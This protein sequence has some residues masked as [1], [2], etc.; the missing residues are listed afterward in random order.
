MYPLVISAVVPRP[1][2]FI[3]SQSLAGVRNLSPYS[4]FNVMSHDPPY[5]CIG[6]WGPRALPR[7]IVALWNTEVAKLLRTAEMKERMTG[8]GIDPAGG[9]PAEFRDALKSDIER[10]QKVIKAA[11]IKAAE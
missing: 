7:E 4:Y 1:I 6:M 5:V 10:W 11:G 3:S 2:A 9:P 8:A